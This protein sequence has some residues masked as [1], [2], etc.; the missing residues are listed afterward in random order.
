[1]TAAIAGL[2]ALLWWSGA[3][4]LVAAAGIGWLALAVRGRM[5][6]NARRDAGLRARA[7]YEHRLNLRG[8]PRGV[9]GRFPPV[10]P[11]WFPDPGN[12]SRLRYFDGGWWTGYTASAGQ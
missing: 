7:E 2:A 6:A 5:R 3:H 4:V 11:G 1:M 9:Y 8:D 10:Q 12:R